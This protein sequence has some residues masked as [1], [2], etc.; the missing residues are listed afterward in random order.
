ME[1]SGSPKAGQQGGR[2]YFAKPATSKGT[3]M[4]I[5]R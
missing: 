5:K 1:S 3:Q 2:Y 4:W